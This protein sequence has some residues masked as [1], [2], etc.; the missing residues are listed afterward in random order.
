MMDLLLDGVVWF[1]AAIV[2]AVAAVIALAVAWS[3]RG[4]PRRLVIAASLHL[5]HACLFGLMG[6][7][8][9]VA[10]SIEMA[11]GTL[12]GSPWLLYPLG[13]ALFVPAALIAATAPRLRTAGPSARRRLA[14]L[15]ASIL[16][17]LTALGPSAVLGIPA[18]LN[19]LHLA[20]ARRAVERAVLVLS[21]LFYL[22]IFAASL[23]TDGG[24]F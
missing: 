18:A 1:R 21:G 5:S 12:E 4:A 23:V 2:I 13:L 24:D 9:L 19:L 10:V 8:H 15:D 3:R 17:F 16:L 14:V 11:R 6:L 20:S 22:A 7:G